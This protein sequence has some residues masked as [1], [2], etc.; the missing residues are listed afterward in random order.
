MPAQTFQTSGEW[1]RRNIPDEDYGS[2]ICLNFPKYAESLKV[3]IKTEAAREHKSISHFIRD[4]C[5]EKIREQEKIR[6]DNEAL[7]GALLW[8]T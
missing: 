1:I 6:R 4:C 8:T 3:K 5:A 7:R 2:A